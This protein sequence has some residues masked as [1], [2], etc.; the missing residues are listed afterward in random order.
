LSWKQ[1]KWDTYIS[2]FHVFGLILE[3][4]SYLL[5]TSF[6]IKAASQLVWWK[7]SPGASEIFL[8]D[9]DWWCL[10]STFFSEKVLNFEF[11]CIFDLHKVLPTVKILTFSRGESI[12]D[13]LRRSQNNSYNLTNRSWA[14]LWSFRAMVML[15]WWPHTKG[16]VQGRI[17]V[18]FG[19]K[20]K[21]FKSFWVKPYLE[22]VIA[23]LYGL[24]DVII[25]ECR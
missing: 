1:K 13:E 12:K 19:H 18:S 3:R 5:F 20:Y 24:Y 16:L 17:S 7:V 15:I 14:S 21:Y 6:H 23:L 4:N 9:D 2:E 10:W 25:V 11:W 22:N 8:L